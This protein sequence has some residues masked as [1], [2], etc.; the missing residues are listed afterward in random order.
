MCT[1][2]VTF[3]FSFFSS[4]LPVFSN[5]KRYLRNTCR[6]NWTESRSVGNWR[7]GSVVVQPRMGC[8]Q[9]MRF[10]G[11]QWLVRRSGKD[12]PDRDS[13]GLPSVRIYPYMHGHL[14]YPNKNC[15]DFRQCT[16]LY[17]FFVFLFR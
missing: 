6:Q 17:G 3:F 13:A 7:R 16:D 11:L 12:P 1:Y 15:T 14:T 5:Y 8:V 2:I 9:E 4:P 10:R